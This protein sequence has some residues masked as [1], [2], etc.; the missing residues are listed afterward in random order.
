MLSGIFYKKGGIELVKVLP[1]AAVNLLICVQHVKT[2][3]YGNG[4]SYFLVRIYQDN[5]F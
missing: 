1:P 4:F 2:A 3:V 5:M